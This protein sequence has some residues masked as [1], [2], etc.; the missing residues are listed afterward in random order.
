MTTD[1]NIW[2]KT[3]PNNNIKSTQAQGGFNSE[4]WI[5]TISK[6]KKNNIETISKGKRNNSVKKYSLTA[7]LFVIGLIFVSV[8]KTET[9]DLQKEISNLLA[10]INTLKYD[11]HQSTLEHEVITSPENISRLAKE[12]LEIDLKPY[13]KS[14]IKKLDNEVETFTE[15]N[16]ENNDILKNSKLTNI[17]SKISKKIEEKK[18]KIKKLYSNPQSVPGEVKMQITKKIKEKKEGIKSIYNDPKGIITYERVQRW[19]GIQVVKVFLG[20]PIVPGK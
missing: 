6:E 18:T 2:V 9:R 11:L 7:I 5:E 10:S 1:P 12:Y 14:Q 13:K 16:K 17:K 15:P 3:L 19:A 20:I 4:K 8:I